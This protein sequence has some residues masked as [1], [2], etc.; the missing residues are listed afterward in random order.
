MTAKKKKATSFAFE[1]FLDGLKRP[2]DTIHLCTDVHVRARIQALMDELEAMPDDAD[3]S[4]IGNPRRD[5]IVAELDAIQNDEANWTAFTVQAP[6]REGRVKAVVTLSQGETDADGKSEAM[7][8]AEATL[9]ANCLIAIGGEPVDLS[10]ED[11]MEMQERMADD[12]FQELVDAIRQFGT[13]VNS[14]PFSQRL[15]RI[16]ETG[17]SSQS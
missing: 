2:E 12:L 6:T 8:H 10:V 17:T 14:V 1:N 11:A 7:L 15:S 9:V 5:E 16:L 4:L 3:E 13:D